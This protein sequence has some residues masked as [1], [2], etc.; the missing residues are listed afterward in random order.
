MWKTTSRV[1][2][3]VGSRSGSFRLLH[4]RIHNGTIFLEISICS[5]LFLT[6]LQGPSWP[7]LLLEAPGSL[8]IYTPINHLCSQCDWNTIQGPYFTL[9]RELLYEL[10]HFIPCKMST[11]WA[12]LVLLKKQKCGGCTVFIPWHQSTASKILEQ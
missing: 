4:G 5:L 6:I 1:G 11:V 3:L 7:F 2:T 10:P 12:E 9:F 8:L